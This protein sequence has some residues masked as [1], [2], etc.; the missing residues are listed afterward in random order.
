MRR[1]AGQDYGTCY[2]IAGTLSLSRERE[3]GTTRVET[4][5]MHIAPP[6]SPFSPLSFSSFG[7]C[8]T[9]DECI[10]N[11]KLLDH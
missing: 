5:V 6:L 3:R 4:V 7:Q 9:F 1:R 11:L 10:C 2:R 8:S